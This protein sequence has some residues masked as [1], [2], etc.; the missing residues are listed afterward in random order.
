MRRIQSKKIIQIL[1]TYLL[2]V[3][4]IKYE[5]M[6]IVPVQKFSTHLKEY[7]YIKHCIKSEK[8]LRI[9]F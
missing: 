2:H 7:K 8:A 9:L 3:S 1:H 5:K 6:A 4:N